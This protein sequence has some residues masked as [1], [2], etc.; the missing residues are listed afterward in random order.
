MKRI[1]LTAALILLANLVGLGQSQVKPAATPGAKASTTATHDKD[2]NDGK[3]RADVPVDIDIT[4]DANGNPTAKDATVHRS[5]HEVARWNNKMGSNCDV[6][7]SP[8]AKSNYN[9]HVPK[10]GNQMAGP[11]VGPDGT[12]NYYIACGTK[13]KGSKAKTDPAIIVTN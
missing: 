4:P 13:K 7:F 2:H 9:Y 6:S 1:V 3:K 5:K 10:T 8:F 12:Y 11:I